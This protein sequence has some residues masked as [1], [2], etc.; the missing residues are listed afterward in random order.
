MLF[1]SGEVVTIA[2]KLVIG[3]RRRIED[4]SAGLIAELDLR[5]GDRRFVVERSFIELERYDILALERIV[6]AAAARESQRDHN[7]NESEND[8]M[9]CFHLKTSFQF[10]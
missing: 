8:Q 2:V 10:F 9:L 3:D 5:F 7:E 1:R 4:I 6:F